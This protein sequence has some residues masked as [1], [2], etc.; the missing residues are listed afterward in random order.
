MLVV[1]PAPLLDL[2]ALESAPV[3]K[4]PISIPVKSIAITI[5]STHDFTSPQLVSD[6]YFMELD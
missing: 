5:M 2:A 1:R 4:D 6:P 3:P